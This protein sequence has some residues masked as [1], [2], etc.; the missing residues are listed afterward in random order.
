MHGDD[1][2]STLS[3]GKLLYAL[4]FGI[5]CIDFVKGYEEERGLYRH[6]VMDMSTGT[7]G[8]YS[9]S[10]CN[11][12]QWPWASQQKCGTPLKSDGVKMVLSYSADLI[13]V[14]APSHICWL[15]WQ[16]EVF[17][18]FPLSEHRRTKRAGK[19]EAV[20]SGGTNCYELHGHCLA[21][22]SFPVAATG[23][24]QWRTRGP[25]RFCWFCL[26]CR[27][28]FWVCSLKQKEICSP[29]MITFQRI[30]KSLRLEKITAIISSNCSTIHQVQLIWSCPLSHD[31]QCHN[32]MFLE[33]L[34]GQW[35][36]HFPRQPVPM[37]YCNNLTYNLTYLYTLR[38]NIILQT[39]PPLHSKRRDFILAM[40]L[41]TT[42]S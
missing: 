20:T 6:S 3:L 17:M 41:P 22:Q 8:L 37:H 24:K 26:A 15:Q 10:N 16:M 19:A 39:S 33:H 42:Y 5:N 29:V 30:I 12:L 1:F 40:G 4:H 34:N 32:Y 21:L 18:A 2:F 36:H 14:Q 23:E 25:R 38:V 9:Q 11:Q 35:L 28:H 27:W 7:A 13:T 31:H